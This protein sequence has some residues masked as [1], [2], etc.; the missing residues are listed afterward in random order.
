MA[1]SSLVRRR[2]KGFKADLKPVVRATSLSINA[3]GC[4]NCAE[5]SVCK[6]PATLLGSL[7]DDEV[8]PFT[9]SL[10]VT[11]TRF[12]VRTE[13]AFDVDRDIVTGS[14]ISASSESCKTKSPTSALCCAPGILSERIGIAG[15][16]WLSE[17]GKRHTG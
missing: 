2:R 14:M 13:A 10:K 16:Y 1:G 5:L 12:D 4:K 6:G 15:V 17:T 3:N 9:R 7:R 11:S 8:E